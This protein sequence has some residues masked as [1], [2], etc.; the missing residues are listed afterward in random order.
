MRLTHCRNVTY[1]GT[2]D[3]HG[4]AYLSIY[5]WLTGPL[6]E[7]YIIESYGTH[8]PCSDAPE[9]EQHGNMTSDDG[10]Y[11]IWTKVR[12]NKPSIQGTTTFTQYFSIRTSKR[13]GG[14]VTTNNH[15]KAWAA[16]G[17]KIGSQNYM[18]VATEGQDSNGTA[19]IN[20][21]VLPSST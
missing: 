9:A 11:E 13:V 15:F 19:E 10:V 1:S 8:K 14:T 20:V 12:K 6:V 18:I 2:F 16:A 21:G 17:L 4:N 5:G 3:P 7:Y